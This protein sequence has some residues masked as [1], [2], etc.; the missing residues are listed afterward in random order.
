MMIWKW[1]IFSNVGVALTPASGF[2]G[3]RVQRFP[4]LIS[5]KLHSLFQL[6]HCEP[7]VILDRRKYSRLITSTI[8]Y[9]P[10]PRILVTIRNLPILLNPQRN[11]FSLL[12]ELI[13]FDFLHFHTL[14]DNNTKN[15][16]QEHRIARELEEGSQTYILLGGGKSL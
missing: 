9:L 10:E 8:F 6:L 16:T 1:E 11:T 4:L 14:F 5:A 13:A 3:S 12:F 15:Y 7:I 2:S